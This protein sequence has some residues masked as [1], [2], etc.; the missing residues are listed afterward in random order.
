LLGHR[1]PPLNFVGFYAAG[2]ETALLIWLSVDKHGAADRA[3]HEHG[4]GWLIRIGEVLNGPL[5]LVLRFFSFVPF[6]AL[7]FL[8]GA[9]VSRVGWISVGK[10]S[11]SD[12]ES[13]F[14]AERY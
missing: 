12:P 14:A 1:I 5:A 13:V 2:V 7:S 3:I 4:T 8:I 6:A 9:L 10:V 11:G